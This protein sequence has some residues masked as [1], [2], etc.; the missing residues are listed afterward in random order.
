[1]TAKT[2]KNFRD[3][4]T[5]KKFKVGDPYEGSVERENYLMN[6]GYLEKTA[7]DGDS[8]L[9]GNV[10]DVKNALDGLDEESLNALLKEEIEG[11]NRKGELDHIENLLSVS[12][13]TKVSE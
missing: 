9:L 6:L 5:Q 11:K 13:Q 2:I 1:M 10:E 12:E 3:K 8:R 4:D 7:E